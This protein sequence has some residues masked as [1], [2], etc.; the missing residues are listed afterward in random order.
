M[1]SLCDDFLIEKTM[2][3]VE[4]DVISDTKWIEFTFFS[5]RESIITGK[6]LQKCLMLSFVSLFKFSFHN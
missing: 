5:A 3:T 4:L 1:L 6:K 2:S